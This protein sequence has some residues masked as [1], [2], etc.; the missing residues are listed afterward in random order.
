[1]PRA[2]LSALALSLLAATQR[3]P[4]LNPT[5]TIN[6]DAAAN[7][8]AIDP[9]IYGVAF[10]DTNALTDLGITINRW[11]GNAMSRYNWAISTANRCKDFYFENQPDP[12]SMGDGSNGKSADD[13]IGP[14]LNAGAQPIMTIPMMGLLPK[15][16]TVRCGY[17]IAK[18]GAQDDYDHGN[19][20]DC[21]NGKQNNVR[22]KHVNDPT[23]TSA[24]YTSAHQGNWIQH[25][26]DTWGA[27][28]ANGVKYY[29][30]DNEPVLWSYDHWDVHPDGSTYDEVWSKMQDYGAMI[31]AK[32]PSSIT[33]AIEE[34]GWSG[35]FD[36]GVDTENNNNADRLAHGDVPYA[37]WILQQAKAYEQA[38]G[39]RIVDFATVHF[40]PQSGEFSNDTSMA[41]QL[42]RNRSTRSLWDP[43]YVDESWIGGTGIDGGHVRLIPRLKEWV[44]NDYPGTHIGITEYNW[45]AEN[46]INGATAQADILG[47]F[48]REALELG[49]RWTSPPSGS[50]VYNAFKM[51]RNYDGAHSHFGDLSVSGSSPNADNLSTFAALRS[52]DGAMTVMVIAKTLSGDT[53]VTVNLSNYLPAGAAQRWQLDAG[54]A[55]THLADV[56]LAGSSL[57]LTVPPQTIT[58]LVV[59]GSYL[60]PP[61]SVTATASSASNV[62]VNWTAANGALS[63]QIYRSTSVGGP[64]NQ[65]GTAAATTFGDSGLT[66]DTTY[67]YRVKSVSGAAVSPLS[68][69]DPAT[70]TVFADDPLNPGVV[71]QV[72]HITQLRTAANAMRAAGGLAPQVFTDSP[73]TAGASIKAVHI[74]QLRTALDQARAAIGVPVVAYTDPTITPGVTTLK[75]AHVTDLRNG[76]K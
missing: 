31:K 15:D 11:G 1:M 10:A 30:L 41:T 76:V 26:V 56:S 17:S 60:D 28:S 73:L 3:I 37:E 69:L 5:V 36:S 40:Y 66:A 74:T 43:N 68:A 46:H 67:L 71:A 16:R 7:R 55:I 65:I 63:Y 22:M 4:N 75:A 39:V 57:S 18:Y 64:F 8:H 49:V 2:F 24:T 29:A 13:F 9:R 58:L 61:T 62:T 53:P 50:H 35:Y 6:V 42:L 32:D 20:P 27:A 52:S 19:W 12:V 38:H 48:G 33:T 51:Y 21:G 14:T 34:W 59:P 25:L 47:I 72:L 45:G 54:N 70:T 23:D 44:A